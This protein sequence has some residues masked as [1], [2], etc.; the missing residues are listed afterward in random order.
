MNI[1]LVEDDAALAELLCEELEAEGYQVQ[2]V[3]SVEAAEPLLETHNID[4]V[5][6]DLRLPGRNGITL[7]PVVKAMNNAPAMLLITAFG[8]V[9]QAVQALKAGADDFLTKPFDMDHCLLTV[10]RLLEHRQLKASVGGRRFHGMLG[11]SA[12]MQSLFKSIEQVARADGPVLVLGES[13]TGKELVAKAIHQ[14][15]ERKL[16]PFLAVNCAGIPSELLESEF[17]GHAAGAYTGAGKSRQGLLREAE[18]G[19]LLLDE[20]GEMPLALQAKLLRVLQEGTVRPVGSDKEVRVDVRI[21]AATHRDPE[22]MVAENDF[23]ED[24]FFRLETFT[25]QV[26]PLRQRGDDIALLTRYFLT[27]QQQSGKTQARQLSQAAWQI[28]LN[29]HFPGNVRELQNAMERAAVFCEGE[30]IK[31]EHLPQRLRQS[32]DSAVQ[33]V[34]EGLSSEALPPLVSL[35][36]DYVHYVLEK[37]QGNKAHAA[38]ILGVTRR[39]LYRWL[40]EAQNEG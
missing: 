4:L 33:S 26:P 11:E 24:L 27:Q 20:I 1:L 35:Q 2:A 3:D 32:Q 36:Q 31:P 38:Q 28:L 29:Y 30:E 12:A 21:I 25:L 15:S 19:T 13:G 7:L 23:R 34:F 6:S 18:G 37:T 17:F 40:E 5:I 9:D 39:T 14:Q 10:R 22:A 16:G 8:S